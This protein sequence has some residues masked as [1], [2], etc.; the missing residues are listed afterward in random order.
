MDNFKIWFSNHKLSIALITIVLIA[1]MLV[2]YFLFFNN[3][4]SIDTVGQINAPNDTTEISQT[5]ENNDADTS[6][7]KTSVDNKEFNDVKK[8]FGSTKNTIVKDDDSLVTD[9][10]V[11]DKGTK[12]LTDGVTALYNNNSFDYNDSVKKIVDTY[13]FSY[14]DTASKLAAVT[15]N[16]KGT[17][18][19]NS[20][21]FFKDNTP[22]S[23]AYKM[24]FRIIS[25]DDAYAGKTIA[26]DGYYDS[27]PN[28]IKISDVVIGGLRQ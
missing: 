2:M 23:T 17:V 1:C 25:S 11:I 19:T 12:C 15:L 20:I 21:K 4:R 24:T 9:Q 8:D 16:Q 3:A 14:D 18:D 5:D 13:F 28:Q 27:V 26:V 10:S 22:N 6:K 7:P